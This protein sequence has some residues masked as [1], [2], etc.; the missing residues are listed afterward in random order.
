MIAQLVVMR[1]LAFMAV[2]LRK[3]RDLPE[4]VRQKRFCQQ[5]DQPGEKELN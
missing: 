3:R 2:D 1:D 5:A 4:Q